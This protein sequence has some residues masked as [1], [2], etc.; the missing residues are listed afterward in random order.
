MKAVIARHE[1]ISE[2]SKSAMHREDC[3]V[4]DDEWVSRLEAN[5]QKSITKK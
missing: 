3:F 4:R 5:H 2:L 1:A